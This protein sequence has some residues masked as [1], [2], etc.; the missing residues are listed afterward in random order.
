M[1]KVIG[2]A[3]SLRR[4]SY[5][6][7]LLGAAA[8]TAPAGLE[9]EIASIRE[10]PLY[11]GDLEDTEGLPAAVVELKDR[12]AASDGLIMVT[13]EYNTSVPGVLKNAMDWLSRPPKDSG[14]VFGGKA[15]ALMGA[16]PGGGGTVLS[17]TAWLPIIRALRLRLWAGGSLQVSRAFEVFD[18][19][20]NLTD[21]K[22]RERL[23]KYMTGFAAFVAG[24]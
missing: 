4:G 24:E 2:F 15:L 10:I 7:A 13:P 19:K 1:A 18:E 9:V 6:A 23:R 8:E 11:D 3:G 17:Q 22:I 21:E 12:I 20:G 14:R 5:N 16:T